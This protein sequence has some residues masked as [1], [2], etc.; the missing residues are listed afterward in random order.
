MITP[1][2]VMQSGPYVML[3]AVALTVLAAFAFA[4]RGE[5]AGEDLDLDLGASDGG[6]G[7]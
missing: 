6:D 7:D 4:S 5:D 2:T 3:A 1:E